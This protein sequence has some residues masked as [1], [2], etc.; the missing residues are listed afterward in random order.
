MEFKGT[1]NFYIIER[2]DS[3]Q[4]KSNTQDDDIDVWGF[5]DKAKAEANAKLIAAAPDL[6]EALHVCIAAINATCLDKDQME[7]VLNKSNK[8][9]NKALK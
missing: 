9:I 6:L 7:Y 3:F 8:A 4:L 1:T 2:E 5:E